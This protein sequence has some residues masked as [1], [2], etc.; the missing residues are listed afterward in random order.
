ML[1][2]LGGMSRS[3]LWNGLRAVAAKGHA[4]YNG[5]LLRDPVSLAG[6]RLPEFQ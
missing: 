4:G 3:S 2:G 5:S 1:E 6:P